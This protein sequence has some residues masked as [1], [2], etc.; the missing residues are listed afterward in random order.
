MPISR[1]LYYGDPA[2]FQFEHAMDHRPWIGVW[3]SER[4]GYTSIPYFIDAPD[5]PAWRLNHQQ[6]HWDT[7]YAPP[8][9]TGPFAAPI[10]QDL[11]ING[12]TGPTSNAATWWT[13]A[14]H[15]EH[16]AVSRTMA[17][18]EWDFYYPFW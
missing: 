14:N 13:F 1:L 4:Q 16:Y 5:S 11:L 17:E 6:A 2:T 3:E 18:N 15:A 7:V 8:K 12:P 10:G 9:P